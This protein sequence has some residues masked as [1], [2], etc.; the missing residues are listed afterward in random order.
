MKPSFGIGSNRQGKKAKITKENRIRNKN[1]C[2]HIHLK[3]SVTNCHLTN[4]QPNNGENLS[5]VFFGPKLEL[6]ISQILTPY[7]FD[8]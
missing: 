6:P 7:F 2:F 5:F 8:R 1:M 4:I 3:Q